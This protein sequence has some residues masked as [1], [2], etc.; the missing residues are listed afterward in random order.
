MFNLAVSDK[1]KGMLDT[2]PRSKDHTIVEPNS[3]H[4]IAVIFPSGK[5]QHN[6]HIGTLKVSSVAFWICSP[7]NFISSSSSKMRAT[8]TTSQKDSWC[9]WPTRSVKN[10]KYLWNPEQL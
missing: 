3:K 9:R 8:S 7:V 4:Q 10:T 2:I 1:T 5:S 6:R